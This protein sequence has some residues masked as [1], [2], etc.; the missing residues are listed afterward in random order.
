MPD[1][2][3]TSPTTPSGRFEQSVVIVTGGGSGIG[4]EIATRFAD[5]GA[6]VAVVGRRAEALRATVSHAPDQ[7][8]AVVA[9][10]AKPGESSRIVDT[11]VERFGRIDVLVNNAALW[12]PMALRNTSDEFIIESLMT[13]QFAVFALIRDAHTH[14]RESAGCVVNISSTGTRV[15]IPGDTVYAGT[16][17]AV[18]QM[19]RNLAVE[20]GKWGIRLNAV[21]PGL[22]GT[23]MVSSN[24]TS[25]QIEGAVKQIPMRRMGT[26]ADIA[27]VVLFLAS[28]DAGWV[29][30]QT[31]QAAGGQML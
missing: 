5:E 19:T 1:Q 29:T 24:L 15:P 31:V 12:V 20:L 21:A 6:L 13:N 26:T 27:K 18:E 30:G 17:A 9:D 11:V 10:V 3:S 22:T 25:E 16:K 14:L 2:P 28:A 7:I 8:T 23:D 4:Q